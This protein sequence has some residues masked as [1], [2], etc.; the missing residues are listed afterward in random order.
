MGKFNTRTGGEVDVGQQQSLLEL[1]VGEPEQQPRGGS[2]LE[3][4]LNAAPDVETMGE[5]IE[6]GVEKEL[7]IE[8][9]KENERVQ[10][11][12]ERRQDETRVDEYD[13]AG[14]IAKETQAKAAKAATSGV[15]ADGGLSARAKNMAAQITSTDPDAPGVNQSAVIRDTLQKSQAFDENNQISTPFLQ[16]ASVITENTIAEL[17]FGEGVE[18]SYVDE[19][20]TGEGKALKKV[21]DKGVN[22][23][24]KAQG[25]SRLGK[26][27]HREWQRYKNSQAGVP[28]D[29]YTDLNNDEA[30][31]LGDMAK[32]LYYETNKMESG[33]QFIQRFKTDDGQVAFGLTKH[34][35]DMIKLG[36]PIRKKMFPKQ[37]VRPSKTPLP[38]G[39]LAGEGNTYTKRVTG[40]AGIPA[41]MDVIEKAMHNLG[42]V[43]NVVDKQRLKILLA[44]AL[45]V[46]QGA[47]TGKNGSFL[48]TINH[49]G[50]NKYQEFQA[51]AAADPEFNADAEYDALVHDLAQDIFG[52]ATEQ[53]GANYLTYYVQAFNG[54]IA[55]QQ[56]HFDPTR[57]KTVRF[58]TRNA[59]PA[60]ATKGSRIEGNLRQMYAMMLVDNA[61]AALPKQRDMLLDRN[62]TKL[63]GWGREL[64]QLIDSIPDGMLEQVTEAITQGIPVSDP[65]F[66]KIPAVQLQNPELMKAIE[67]KG[68][69]GQAFIDGLIDFHNYRTA[70]KAGRPHFSYFNAYMDGKT[71]GLAANGM[72]MG[73]IPMAYKTGVLRSQGKRLL[74]NDM[75]IR[76]DLK[77]QLLELADQGFQGHESFNNE[78]HNIATKVYGL[79][80]L[81]KSTTMTFGYGMELSSFKKVIKEHM[82]I[83]AQGDPELQQSITNATQSDPDQ[84][85][86][87]VD[88]LH[89]VYV[90]G[91]A[92]ALDPDALASRGVMRSAAMM[93]ALTNELFSIKSPVGMDL[94]FGGTDTTGYETGDSYKVWQGKDGYR[95]T[96]V[97]RFGE[98]TTSAAVKRRTDDDGITQS[99]PGEIAY[100]GSVP[101][102]VQ[103]I[104]AATVALTA[105]GRSWNRLKHASNGNPYLHTIYD[106]FKVDAMGYDVVLDEVNRNWVNS[107][108]DWSYLEQTRDT[109][110]ELSAKWK[111]KAAS[112]PDGEA[113]PDNQWKMAGYLLK[114]NETSSGGKAPTNLDRK[115]RTLKANGEEEN[116]AYDARKRVLAKMSKVGFNVYNPPAKPTFLHLKTLVSAVN[117][118]LN[119]SPRLNEMIHRTNTNKKAL[120]AK[121]KADGNKV[122]QYYSH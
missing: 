45:P 65:K 57:S 5:G 30:T 90:Q 54:R 16:M 56:S 80:D 46:L 28:T 113:V 107:S 17:A 115:F 36:A 55:P 70:V 12:K 89:K 19:V 66:P 64:K 52:I 31:A 68:E 71:N 3:E 62:T 117:A 93:H 75:D 100:G 9:Q 74:D 81:N 13:Y 49:V 23:I 120:K 18:N 116:V 26:Q 61:D 42:S 98:E 29:Q 51:K 41:D 87:L 99:I 8:T 50:A 110:K 58:V 47:E 63:D 109:M 97:G 35:A 103:S 43:P 102:P 69:D 106:A 85:K 34:G 60:K 112:M 21:A 44:T 76:D 111:A 94:M 83:M 39:R 79:R 122:Y 53:N 67:K 114:L 40:K 14:N 32:E 84:M 22:P 78:L 37:H 48:A 59:V 108:M 1:P 15:S 72:Q 24:T 95:Q 118:E 88:T 4:A 27:I 25:N 105:S 92:Q 82:E 121:I 20:D 119:L 11:I 2:I 86:E 33:K 101:G 73:S 10:P 91:L 77:V 96:A 38:G 6:A 104:D 7:A